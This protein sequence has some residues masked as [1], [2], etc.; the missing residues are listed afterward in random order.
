MKYL[1]SLFLVLSFFSANMLAQEDNKEMIQSK[2][3]KFDP[4]ASPA[5]DLNAAIEA[6]GV[7]GKRILL[8]VGGEWCK[9]CHLFDKFLVEQTEI[10]TL[11]FNTFEVVKVNV[12]K[13]NKNEAFLS[14]YPKVDGYPHFFVLESDGAFLHSQNTGELEHES[15][16]SAEKLTAFIMNW[17]K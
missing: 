7:S 2:I 14:T 11:F 1:L 10:G 3:Q 4:A 15:S 5:D 16:Y 8:D 12:S 17:K 9:W 13:E 6:A